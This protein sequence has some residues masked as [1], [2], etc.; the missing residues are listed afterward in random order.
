MTRQSNG[1]PSSDTLQLKRFQDNGSS[2][3][4]ANPSSSVEFRDKDVGS[5]SG[6]QHIVNG[7]YSG[8]GR[9]GTVG[10]ELVCRMI[11]S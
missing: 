9:G 1:L 2:L 11:V 10:D 3:E 6:F 8:I 7:R 4:P 5:L